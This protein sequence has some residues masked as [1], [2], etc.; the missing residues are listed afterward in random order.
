MFKLA[1]LL[2]ILAGLAF[3]QAALTLTCPTTAAVGS[4]M[5]PL[6]LATPS[7]SVALQFAVV[8][9]SQASGFTA[10]VAPSVASQ[11]S[12]TCAANGI[13]VIYGGQS[14]IPA[15]QIATIVFQIPKTAKGTNLPNCAN[16][17]T[18]GL[19]SSIAVDA[20]AALVASTVNP[21]SSA[22]INNAC[23]VTGDGQATAADIAAMVSQIQKGSP[24][25]ADLNSDGAVNVLDL[26]IEINAVTS[27]ACSAK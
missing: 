10:T 1:S 6:S 14:A 23:D 12:L 25:T 24:A 18:V 20:N 4:L 21:S 11:K 9:P 3:A 5:C 7:G 17:I 15:G 16:C 19:S 13:C 8:V 2:L 26:Q 27:G 22:S